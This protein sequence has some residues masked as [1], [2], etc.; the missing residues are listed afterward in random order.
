VR[1]DV[2]LTPAALPAPAL[3]GATAL[4]VDVLRASTTMIT[5]LAHGCLAVL[6]VGE[7]EAA[8]RRVADL[9][10]A[11]L[12]GERGGD[13]PAGFD[14]GNSP[15]EF[16]RERVGG[17]T[18]VFTTSNG[19]RALL[20]A[21]PAAA[22]A[23]AGFVNLGAAAA[24]AVGQGHDLVVVCAGELGGRSL[25]DE[26]C[27]GLLVDRVL[28]M[29]AGAVATEA[30]ARAAGTARP[31]AKDLARLAQDAPHARSLAAHGRGPDVTA[32]LTLDSVTMVP[33]YRADVDK[34]VSPY[35]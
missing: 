28:G 26:I 7:V 2:A 25:E 31:Y 20:A 15:L 17:R 9:P 24:W 30:A 35:R 18:I 8:R 21:R 14:L 3:A 33:V 19:T 22:V 23:V 16:T 12:A 34:V 32:C 13:P 11:L 5:A 6:P 29:E 1:V 10:G 27:A 4:V